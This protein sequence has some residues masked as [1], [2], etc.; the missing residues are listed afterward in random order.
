MQA[1][2]RRFDY[3]LLWVDIDAQF[4]EEPKL[5]YGTDVDFAIHVVKRQ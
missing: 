2:M 3:P 5:L 1:C 4:V